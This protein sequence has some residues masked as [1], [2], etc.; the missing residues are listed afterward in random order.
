[1]VIPWYFF[2]LIVTRT[3]FAFKKTLRVLTVLPIITPPFVIGLALI[4]L[5]ARLSA[6]LAVA[7]KLPSVF[8]VLIAG[9]I[10]GPSVTHLV[11]ESQ[12]LQ[13]MASVGV[14]ILLF[15]AGASSTLTDLFDPTTAK[16]IVAEVQ[17]VA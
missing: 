6:Q 16:K 17:K 9:V 5:S 13:G 15:V 7:L 8:G 1:M 2:A 14:V 12:T 3:G 10:L 11:P 4:L